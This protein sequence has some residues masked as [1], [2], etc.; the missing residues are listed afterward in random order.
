M[1]NIEWINKKQQLADPLTTS[2]ANTNLLLKT[3]S[4]GKTSVTD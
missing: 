3:F 4:T 1:K 2:S